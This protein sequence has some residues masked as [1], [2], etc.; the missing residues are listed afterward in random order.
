[1]R[2]GQRYTGLLSTQAHPLGVPSTFLLPL[3]GHFHNLH[4]TLS[5]LCTKRLVF[6]D[7]FSF[8]VGMQAIGISFD[9]M[10]EKEIKK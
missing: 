5:I 10:K 6:L 4:V 9:S 2:S 3:Y 7:F 1:V 8:F